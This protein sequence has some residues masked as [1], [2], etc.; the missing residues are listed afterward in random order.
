LS[1][2]GSVDF[3]GSIASYDWDFGDA[4]AH[5]SLANPSH[6]YAA[7]T[8]SATVTVTDNEGA[9]GTASVVI[10]STIN[11]APTAVANGTPTGGKSPLAVAFSSAGSVDNDG[12]IASYHWD[13]GDGSPVSTTAN[14]SHTYT[15]QGTYAATLT[16]TDNEGATDVKSVSVNVGPPNVAPVALA[17]GTPT[18]GRAP[19]VVAFDSATSSDSDGTIVSRSWDFGDGSPLD[20]STAPSHTYGAG[21]WTAT[22]TVTD[23][24]GA[25]ATTP[26]TVHSTVNSPP[27]AVAGATPTSGVAALSVAFNSTGSSD[28]DGTIASYSW[29]F[30]DGSPAG[31]GASPSHIYSAAGSYGATVTV[32]DNEGAATTSSAVTITVAANQAPT[33]AAGSDVSSGKTPLAVAFNSTGSTDTDGTIASYDWDFGDGSPHGTT[34]APSHTYTAACSCTATLT[35][36]DDQGATGTATVAITASDNVAP[37]AV[38]S[39]DVTSGDASL[40]VGFDSV[41]S[42]DSDGTITGYSWDFGDGSSLDTT[43]APSHTYTA[44]GTYHAAL[45]VTDNNGATNTASITITVTTPT[46]VTADLSAT[47]T[48]CSLSDP[49]NPTFGLCNVGFDASGSSSVG[50]SIDDYTFNPGD[51]TGDVDMGSSSSYLYNYSV[52]GTW[53]A[54]VKVSGGVRSSTASQTITI[55]P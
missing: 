45:T 43:A 4:S 34:S 18:S 35:V 30:G 46:S 20:S 25:S 1:S 21:T 3:D 36:T 7:G 28:S 47:P 6:T 14:P 48:T 26:V 51:G 11:Q 8:Y 15:T 19:L 42:S 22:L 31:S 33:A 44:A 52:P 53:T 40:A 2:A 10:H 38:P 9:T 27:V 24:D 12:T 16:V 55:T 49:G 54:T 41:L 37:V 32:T 23:N 50:V 17:S 13:F 5:S 29:N 39:A